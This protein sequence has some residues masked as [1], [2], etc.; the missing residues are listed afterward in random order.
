MFVAPKLLPGR[1]A[2]ELPERKRRRYVTEMKVPP[3]SRLDGQSLDESGLQEISGLFLI[4]LERDEVA[5]FAPLDPETELS[6]GDRLA[7]AG[8]REQIVELRRRR[9][10]RTAT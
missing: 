3:G 2:A 4:R 9:G 10:L 1:A 5:T 8:V 6:H 7:F